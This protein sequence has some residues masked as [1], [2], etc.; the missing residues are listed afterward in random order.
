MEKMAQDF[1]NPL[2]TASEP[3]NVHLVMSKQLLNPNDVSKCNTIF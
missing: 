3:E 2:Y 1:N